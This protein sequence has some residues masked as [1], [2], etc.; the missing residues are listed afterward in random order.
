MGGTGWSAGR[1]LE[2]ARLDAAEQTG[3]AGELLDGTGAVVA[4]GQV[5]LE[6]Q[7]LAGGEGAEHV[8]GVVVGEQAAH[9]L[10]PISSS[11]SFSAR[12]A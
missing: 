9:A 12:S 5:P 7:A 8:G 10:T 6:L 2:D 11:A 4:A 3:E 1:V